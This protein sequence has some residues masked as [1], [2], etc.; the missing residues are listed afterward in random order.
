[1][2]IAPTNCFYH[3][4]LN[5]DVARHLVQTISPQAALDIDKAFLCSADFTNDIN[6]VNALETTLQ[7]V[8]EQT[9]NAQVEEKYNPLYTS[10]NVEALDDLLVLEPHADGVRFIGANGN[11]F[12]LKT[13]NATVNGHLLFEAKV[14][15]RPFDIPA[16]ADLLH[17][18]QRTAIN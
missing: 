5:G 13:V 12:I 11:P 16:Y 2:I 17:E 7:S 18:F 1:M 8:Q 3:V 4:L 14:E 9:S 6:A 10:N 15:Y